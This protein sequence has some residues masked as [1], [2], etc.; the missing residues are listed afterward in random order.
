MIS[1]FPTIRDSWVLAGLFEVE[2]SPQMAQEFKLFITKK[3][4]KEIR[5]LVGK[6]KGQIGE[7]TF[8]FKDQ[9]KILIQGTEI[10]GEVITFSK[11]P[12]LGSQFNASQIARLFEYGNEVTPKYGLITE[13]LL[14]MEKKISLYWMEFGVR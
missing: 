14:Q 9:I 13:G 8:L 3:F 12:I 11:E 1:K 5:A 6:K 7:V 10:N 4:A 2:M